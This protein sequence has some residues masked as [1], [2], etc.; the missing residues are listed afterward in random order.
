MVME[1]TKTFID[2]LKDPKPVDKAPYRCPCCA[3]KMEK[4]IMCDKCK[5]RK[6]EEED[7]ERIRRSNQEMMNLMSILGS[8]I[9]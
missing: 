2:W 6:R 9:V 1:E 4:P 8:A 3:E 7:A 5:K